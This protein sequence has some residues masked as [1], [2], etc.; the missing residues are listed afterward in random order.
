[1][2]GVRDELLGVGADLRPALA[3]VRVAAEGGVCL[4]RL[5]GSGAQPP[6][7]L[8]RTHLLLP[9][10]ARAAVRR[11]RHPRHPSEWETCRTRVTKT[12][13]VC[14]CVSGRVHRRPARCVPWTEPRSHLPGSAGRPRRAA[15]TFAH[16]MRPTP[17]VTES[18]PPAG[19]PGQLLQTGN[20]RFR[21][22][23]RQL[24][25]MRLCGH[26]TPP[27]GRTYAQTIRQLGYHRP[28]VRS[29]CR[30]NDVTHWPSKT[31]RRFSVTIILNANQFMKTKRST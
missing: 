25:S 6:A 20:L 16:A 2:R 17:T 8:V 7:E 26:V 30:D 29:A 18:F 24:P 3:E 11:A 14:V 21:S 23:L 22:V 28:C 10:P 9:L 1:M 15:S 13:P 12:S 5:R 31:N 19:F 4:S 27:A